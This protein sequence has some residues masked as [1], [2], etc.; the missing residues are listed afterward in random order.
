M[1]SLIRDYEYRIFIVAVNGNTITAWGKRR[2][3]QQP[4][5]GSGF[6]ALHC[7]GT[8]LL[9]VE[10][11]SYFTVLWRFLIH[12]V[13][14]FLG[15]RIDVILSLR[16]Y[17]LVLTRLDLHKLNKPF[18]IFAVRVKSDV[19]L[20]ATVVN[21]GL[22]NTTSSSCWFGNKSSGH[23]SCA[24]VKVYDIRKLAFQFR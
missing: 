11:I 2:S 18:M 8:I 6:C 12:P 9:Q 10:T 15:Y 23:F 19:L 20:G 5:D 13:N 24:M 1:R 3:S 16:A 14:K 17:S 7:F 4:R 22:S 21:W